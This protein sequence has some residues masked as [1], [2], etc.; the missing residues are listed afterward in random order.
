MKKIVFLLISAFVFSKELSDE[1][2]F[3]LAETISG[4]NVEC[5][6]HDYFVNLNNYIDELNKAYNDKNI[7]QNPIKDYDKY[8]DYFQ[9]WGYQSI[10]NKR[11]FDEFNNEINNFCSNNKEHFIK[12][13]SKNYQ[14]SCENF[15]QRLGMRAFGSINKFIKLDDIYIEFLKIENPEDSIAYLNEISPNYYQLDFLLKIALLAK[16]DMKII[17]FLAKNNTNINSGY[18]SAIFYA[19]DYYEALEY[20]LENKANVNYVNALGKSAIFYAVEIS[21]IKTIKLLMKYGA[22]LNLQQIDS[23]EELKTNLPYYI[24]F[25]SYIHPA[26]TLV[27]HAASLANLNTLK[28]LIENKADYTISDNFGL[29]ALDYAM[30]Y[31]NKE[32]IEYLKKLGLKEKEQ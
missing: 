6:G 29:N 7:Y 26:K 11:L 4:R 2:L 25:C 3:K 22:N 8:Y 30:I 5:N 13:S 14:K 1:K 19:L 18:E 24:S 31:N 20:L 12:L 9:Y 17:E 16:K 27:I 15:I 21:D 23:E 28:L 32:N 10:G